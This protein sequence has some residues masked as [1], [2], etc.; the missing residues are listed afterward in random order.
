MMFA[1]ASQAGKVV[2]CSDCFSPITVPPPPKNP[3]KRPLDIEAAATFQLVQPKTERTRGD[4]PNRKSAQ[5]L[6]AEA[7]R[8]ETVTPK[9]SHRDTPSVR[10]W[11]TSVFGIFRDPSVIT[12]W[13]GLSIV[14]TAAT[15]FVMAANQPYF[16]V[17]LFPAGLLFAAAVVS[18][19]FA[20]LQSIANG[21]ER[22]SDWPLFDPASWFGDLIVAVAAAAMVAAPVAFVCQ[23]LGAGLLG[24]AVTMFAIYAM[25]PFVLLS[26]METNSPWQPFSAEVARSVTKCDEAWGGFYF[27]SGLIFATLF[28]CFVFTAGLGVAGV[29]VSIFAAVAVAF[30]YFAMIGTLAHSIGESSGG[31]P[32]Q[33]SKQEPAAG[34]KQ[35][36]DSQPPTQRR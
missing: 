10:G 15:V 21:E 33:S 34:S 35:S 20:I 27:S 7:A 3:V 19:G 9:L 14:A 26:M 24:V 28:L 2:K 17:V 25:F 23:V 5:Q 22:V 13:A 8:D 30:L 32:P 18:C 36:A 29:V 11:L 4:D 16:Y 6:L 12:Y 31:T 1:K